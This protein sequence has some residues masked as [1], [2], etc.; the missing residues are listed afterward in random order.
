MKKT[1][2]LLLLIQSLIGTAQEFGRADSLRGYLSEYRNCY[3]VNYYHLNIS[4]KPSDKSINGYS[5]IHFDALTDFNTFQIDLFENM[6]I[7][8]IQF[9]GRKQS[10][11]RK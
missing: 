6:T 8:E 10:F 11:S 2:L 7:S 5:E 1:V 4:V 9:E 3:D